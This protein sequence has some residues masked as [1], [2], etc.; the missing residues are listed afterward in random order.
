MWVIS[1]NKFTVVFMWYSAREQ[2]SPTTVHNGQGSVPDSLPYLIACD[3]KKKILLT[4]TW[5]PF[6][7]HKVT[8]STRTDDFYV[9]F[10]IYIFSEEGKN[11]S[12]VSLYDSMYPY[13]A[14]WNLQVISF[15]LQWIIFTCNWCGQL[16]NNAIWGH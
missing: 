12:G 16:M 6:N 11:F 8:A 4:G 2:P 9:S 5:N 14:V 10:F 3:L 15:L 7:K 1:S 13:H